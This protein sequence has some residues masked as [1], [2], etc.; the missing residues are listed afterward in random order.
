[1]ND[2]TLV[3]DGSPPQF[4]PGEVLEDDNSIEEDM[5]IKALEYMWKSI[6][7]HLMIPQKALMAAHPKRFYKCD[8]L[9]RFLREVQKVKY[10]AD[11]DSEH[12]DA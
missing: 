11:Q 8:L 10:G 12:D 2:V 1:M 5:L 6:E 3:G 4:V 7:S 9:N